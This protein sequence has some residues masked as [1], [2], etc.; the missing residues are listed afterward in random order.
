MRAR[1]E[2]TSRLLRLGGAS[3]YLNAGEVEVGGAL[4]S[5]RPLVLDVTADEGVLLQAIVVVPVS[6][7]RCRRLRPSRSRPPSS[8]RTSA[9]TEWF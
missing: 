5:A 6:A 4:D 3:H 7:D 8:R 2:G 9:V 1:V